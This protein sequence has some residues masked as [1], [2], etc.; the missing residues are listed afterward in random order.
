M[1]K[2]TKSCDGLERCTVRAELRLTHEQYAAL[3]EMSKDDGIPAE[4]TLLL[5]TAFE[6][7]C[8]RLEDEKATA[9]WNQCSVDAA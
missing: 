6:A 2:F 9:L 8:E 5:G 7:A 4:L 1:K 3:L